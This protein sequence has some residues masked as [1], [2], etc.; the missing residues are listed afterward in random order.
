MR[1]LPSGS[2]SAAAG[3]PRRE[4]ECLGQ[5]SIDQRTFHLLLCHKR[6]ATFKFEMTR[7]EIAGTMIAVVEICRTAALTAETPDLVAKL[8]ARELQIAAL[9]ATGEATK[10]IAYK[11]RI[12]E[13]TV[14]THLRRIFAKLRVDNRA[15]MVYRCAP[16]IGDAMWTSVGHGNG[17]VE[18]RATIP[19][20]NARPKERNGA[21]SRV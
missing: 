11:L 13:W 10:N 2:T 16:L 19:A 1:E 18:I 12:S 8:T 3:P 6:S 4:A 15:A 9:V 7:F 21:L 14:G 5:F 20:R 17:H